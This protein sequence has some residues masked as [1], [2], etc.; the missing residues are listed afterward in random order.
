MQ[1]RKWC[2]TLNNW[3]EEEFE[4]LL[5]TD[6]DYIII[7]KEVGEQLTPHLQ[8]FL[9]F[10]NKKT[11]KQCKAINGRAHW[12]I[13]KGSVDQNVTY[14]SKEGNVTERGIKPAN[15]K[16]KGIKG[17]AAIAAQWELAKAGKF[18]ELPPASIKTY[19]YIFAKYG[20]KPQDIDNLDNIWIYGTSGCGKSRY[21]R[22]T[23]TRFYSKSIS[24]WWDGYTD[25]EVVVIDDIDPSH[26]EKSGIG[27]NL[28]IWADHYVFNAETKGGTLFIR[29]KQIIVTSQYSIS[30]V[31]TDPET[32]AA[33]SRRF[34][35]MHMSNFFL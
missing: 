1:N 10:K 21:V 32:F 11:L 28:K 22:D 12:E 35:V 17:A 20:H 7:G 15:A 26:A 27:Y 4:N 3:T 2:F 5:K 8:G 25:E 31:F 16:E 18:E 13:A 14:C 33:I 29:P 23:Y 34:R 19:E 30:S 24:K 6:S 9:Y